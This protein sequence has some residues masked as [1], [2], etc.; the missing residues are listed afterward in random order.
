MGL[1]T[2]RLKDFVKQMPLRPPFQDD[3]PNGARA[4][5]WLA[6]NVAAL[7]IYTQAQFEVSFL[8]YYFQME[9]PLRG[10]AS[11]LGQRGSRR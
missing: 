5:W 1:L 10:G 9:D 11:R 6:A 4:L 7:T 3:M 2:E 8:K